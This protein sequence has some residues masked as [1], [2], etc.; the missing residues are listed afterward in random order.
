MGTKHT[1]RKNP[2]KWTDAF[3][4]GLEPAG[5]PYK[6]AEDAPRGQGRLVVRVQPNGSRE[7]FYR[8]R[9][10]AGEVDKTLALG[11][12]DPSGRNGKTLAG[13]REAFREIRDRQ[14]E[15][16]DVKEA[17]RQ[18]AMKD[19]ANRR[20]GTLAQ[21]LAAYADRLKAEGKPSHR[22]AAGIF[23]RNVTRPFPTLAGR[24]AAEITSDDVR[25]I[26]A[27]MVKAGITRGVNKARAYLGAAFSY[28]AEADHD[29]RTAAKDGVLFGIKANPVS[30][31]PVIS[32]YERVLDRILT[33]DELREYWRELDSVPIVQAAT[34]RLNLALACQRPTQLLRADWESFDFIGNT[35]LLRDPKGRGGSRDH[36]L[37]LT[38]FA[39]EQL[40]P[41]RQ[42]NGKAALPFST[43]GKRP[44]SI[45]TL[46][47]AV[48][49]ISSRLEKRKMPAFQQR[50]LRRTAETMLQ[51]LGI[52]R[53][54]RAH[55]LSHGRSTG[56]Q[57]KHYERYDFLKEKREALEKWSR[58]LERIISG[59]AAKVVSIKGAA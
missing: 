38:P 32:E 53:E 55:L 30:L 54:V 45:D 49:E 8:Y 36:L 29:P 40:K 3:I 18:E 47:G 57:G 51:K 15:T 6:L 17:I 11:R 19:D 4:K 43:K 9:G 41:L 22:E 25:L 27:K 7:F 23:L 1:K 12:Y 56:V 52:D 46:T 20:R 34:L 37:P 26:L 42:I 14:Q 16:G 59:K 10:R 39:L 31:V 33:E 2:A 21:L 35:L 13:I 58:Y 5:K 50:D 28:G 44:L 48:A 24:K